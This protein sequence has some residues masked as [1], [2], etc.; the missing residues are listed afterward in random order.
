MVNKEGVVISLFL[1][2]NKTDHSQDLFDQNQ[3]K[4]H[5]YKTEQ[6]KSQPTQLQESIKK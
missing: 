4:L 1:V 3:F 6:I 2:L 5:K